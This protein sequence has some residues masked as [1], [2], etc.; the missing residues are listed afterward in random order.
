MRNYL[1]TGLTQPKKG[2]NDNMLELLAIGFFVNTGVKAGNDCYN[3]VKK[4]ILSADLK[5]VTNKVKNIGH[6]DEKKEDN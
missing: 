4:I 1:R 6:K 5:A 3:T 2:D